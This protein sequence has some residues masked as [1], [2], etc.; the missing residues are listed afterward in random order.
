M[1]DIFDTLKEDI[2]D[3]VDSQKTQSIGDKITNY[4]LP[5]WLT[6]AKFEQDKYNIYGDIG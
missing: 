2:F 6:Q 3:K 4:I 1:A 5:Q